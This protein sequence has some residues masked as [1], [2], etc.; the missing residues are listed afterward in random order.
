MKNLF[1]A[2]ILLFIALIAGC[3]TLP[4]SNQT[5]DSIAHQQQLAQISHW[6]IKGR[7]AFK[8]PEEKFSAYLHW[9]QQNQEFNLQLNTF[10]G[11]TLVSMEGYPGF[12]SL[13]ADNKTYSDRNASE[14]IR[15]VTG[16]NIPVE[17]LAIWVKGQHTNKD[18]VVYDEFGRVESLTANCQGCE[19]WMLT[20]AKYKLFDGIPMPHQISLTNSLEPANQV[21]IRVT[22]WQ[23]L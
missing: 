2:T 8:S 12:A 5:V 21:K 4:P 22:S 23:Q 6:K 1:R 3:T 10:I 14:L 11:T 16:W 13:E 15:R 9:Q 17:K 18:S 7:L 19:G 20:F